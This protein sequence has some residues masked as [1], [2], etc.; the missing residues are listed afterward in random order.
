MHIETT[1]QAA[2]EFFINSPTYRV[3]FWTPSGEVWA[4]RAYVITGATDVTEVL[5]WVKENSGGQQVEVFAEM[6]TEPVES[7]VPRRAGLIRLSRKMIQAADL[8]AQPLEHKNGAPN[9]K[10]GA[11]S[12]ASQL[13]VT[14]LL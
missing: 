11:P 6:D 4:L 3:N 8:R 13:D 1:P 9:A 14:G 5:Q 10:F 7:G 12:L 2:N